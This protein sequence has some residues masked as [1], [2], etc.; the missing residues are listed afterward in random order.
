MDAWQPRPLSAA[1]ALGLGFVYWLAFLLVLE[2]DNLLRA[3]QAGMALPFGTECLRI[4]GAA[5][6]GALT[7]PPMLRL[8]RRYP[9]AGPRARRHLPIHIVVNLGLA[10]VL[11]VASCVLAAWAFEGRLLPTPAEMRQQLVSNATLL[12]FALCAFTAIAQII[13]SRME[14]RALRTAETTATRIAV[15]T[16]GRLRYVALVDVDWIEAQGNYVAL[17]V[18]A[19]AQLVRRTLTDIESELDPARYARIHRSMIVALAR[20]REM[21]TLANG[22]ASLTLADGRALRVSRRYRESVR[23]RWA[24]LGT[25][26][27]PDRVAAADSAGNPSARSR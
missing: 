14:A 13:Q 24:S 12:V 4:G 8:V 2:P 18:G 1:S 26:P 23:E 27:S 3:S 10:V 6:L 5:L 20:I 22:D 15:K 21:K 7:A 17:H 19:H 25:P 9:L 11:I 16:A